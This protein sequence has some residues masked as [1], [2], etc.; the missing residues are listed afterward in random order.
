MAQPSSTP[1]RTD[2]RGTPRFPDTKPAGRRILVADDNADSAETCA[3]LLQLWGHDVR[4]AADGQQALDLAAQ[5]RPDIALI[6][7]GMPRLSGY[8]VAEALRRTDWGRKILL[9]AVTGWGHEEDKQKAAAAGFDRHLSK[10]VDPHDLQPLIEEI[11][12]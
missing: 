8:Q 3:M 4:V 9:V 12:R 2:G 5:F 1:Q 7:I 10:P 11:S 6:D